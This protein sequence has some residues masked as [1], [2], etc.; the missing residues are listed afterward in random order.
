[1]TTLDLFVQNA[2]S[3]LDRD[4][5]T[6]AELS[7]RS[8][9]SRSSITDFFKRRY[10]DPRLSTLERISDAIGVSVHTLLRVPQAEKKKRTKRG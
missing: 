4:K 3:V 9:L 5:I 2:R 8:G 10:P 1:M 6:Y 7:A